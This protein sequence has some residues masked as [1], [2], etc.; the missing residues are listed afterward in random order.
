MRRLITWLKCSKKL[1]LYISPRSNTSDAPSAGVRDSTL[2]IHGSLQVERLGRHFAQKGLKFTQI[3]SSD[4]QRAYK[5]AEAIMLAQ[6]GDEE[7]KTDNKLDIS[8]L[9]VLREQDFGF[10]EGKPF[11]NRRKEDYRL[12]RRKD[13]DFKDVE[14]KD[15]MVLR[16]DGF[17]Q[18]HLLH[19]L[20][21]ER[22]KEESKV[23]VVSHGIILSHLWRC[24]L[25][26]LPR[27]SVT[28]VPGLF[29]EGRGRNVLEHLGVWS[30]TGY[31]ELDI[32][33][34]PTNAVAID[35]IR[36]MAQPLRQ[37]QDPL[38]DIALTMVIKSVNSTEHL[39]TLK[40]TRGGVGSSKYD[41]GQK[42]IE[43]FFKKAK[44]V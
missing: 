6:N 10:R 28:V 21:D 2:T 30:N 40:R 9:A 17:I 4:L 22:L 37:E 7:K 11:N 33:P 26:I 34:V 27:N 13:S 20:R 12:Q 32:H 1:D 18:Q 3:F 15:S 39:K 8:C 44:V 38:G 35:T 42:K 5:T 16:M 43:S 25:K 24:L 19:L 14:S 41:E 23:A 29:L 36:P 31:L